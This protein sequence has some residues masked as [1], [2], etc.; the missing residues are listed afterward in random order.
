MIATPKDSPK[1]F[2]RFP[3][4]PTMMAA[5][6]SL[7][8]YLAATRALPGSYLTANQT[9]EGVVF[10]ITPELKSIVDKWISDNNI[11]G[12]GQTPTTPSGLPGSGLD[13]PGF[14]GGGGDGTGVG[15]PDVEE[16]PETGDPVYEGRALA[17][18][19]LNIC[20]DDGDGGYTPMVTD[21]YST[22]PYIPA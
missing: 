9:K 10:D 2:S 19:Q 1:K 16:D 20:V 22:A 4:I 5:W 6:N 3:G 7:L 12:S 14:G 11:R 21:I 13:T 17:W 15:L 8:D 18:R